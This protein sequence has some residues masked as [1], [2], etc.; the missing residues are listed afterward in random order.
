MIQ[1]KHCIKEDASTLIDF[2]WSLK[3]DLYL[4]EKADAEKIA[5]DLFERGGA[6]A[7]YKDETMIAASGYFLGEPACDYRNK[8]VGFIHVAGIAKPYRLSRVMRNG[9]HFMATFFKDAG[10]TELRFQAKEDDLYINRL[11]AR[12]AKPLGKD[13]NLR[14]I[15]TILYATTV[16]HVLDCLT[17]PPRKRPTPD[18]YHQNLGKYRRT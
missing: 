16:D 3:D 11:Y 12:F 15:Q 4:R 7:G 5:A 9:F 10:V 13:V 18:S 17:N 14:G 6:F 1:F 2:F 8:E